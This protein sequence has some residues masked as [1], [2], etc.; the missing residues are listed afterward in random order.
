VAQKNVGIFEG[1]MKAFNPAD[2]EFSQQK[3]E[4]FST[5]F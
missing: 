1:M 3:S 2:V 5:L 4:V